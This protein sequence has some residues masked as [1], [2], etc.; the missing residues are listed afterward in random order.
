M[1]YT[2]NEEECIKKGFTVEEVHLL[3]LLKLGADIDELLGSMIQEE[4]ILLTDDEYYMLT[5]R[6]NDQLALVL[7]DSDKNKTPED[8]I[9]ELGEEMKELFPKGKKEGTQVYWRGNKRELTLR[10]KKFFKLYGSDYSKEQILKATKDYVE[11][12]N[13][14]YN[15]MRVLKYFIWKDMR[16]TMED[17][18]VQVVE[19][20]ELADHLENVGQEEVIKQDWTKIGRAHV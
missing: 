20:S 1:T 6:W 2:I 19:V 12:F 5:P 9:E 7:L 18:T 13:G 8:I 10:L 11:S 15:N 14:I 4:K 16:K 17:G 3:I